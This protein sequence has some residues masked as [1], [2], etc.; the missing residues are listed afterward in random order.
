MDGKQKNPTGGINE[1]P[2]GAES[3]AELI[4]RLDFGKNL[5]EQL[6]EREALEKCAIDMVVKLKKE[7]PALDLDRL[8]PEELLVQA[9]QSEIKWESQEL[10][11]IKKIREAMETTA[12][13]LVK[14]DFTGALMK[15]LKGRFLPKVEEKLNAQNEKPLEMDQKLEAM[16]TEIERK[17]R[18]EMR[19][20]VEAQADPE[21]LKSEAYFSV[22][23]LLNSGAVEPKDAGGLQSMEN[24]SKLGSK[25]S[26]RAVET[27]NKLEKL[28]P[29]AFASLGLP[30][31]IR[32]AVGQF[33]RDR[34]LARLASEKPKEKET[35]WDKVS[36]KTKE[37]YRNH[38]TLSQ[39]ALVSAGAY[40][41]YRIIKYF[42]GKKA[43]E[44]KAEG[45]SKKEW[46]MGAGAIA[47]VGLGVFLGRNRMAQWF[48]EQFGSL[49]G[50]KET[51]E[52]ANA[53][54]EALKNGKP[55]E[56]LEL[57]LKTPDPKEELHQK[58]S[59]AFQGFGKNIPK[60]SLRL[61]SQM[62]YGAFMGQQENWTEYL[63]AKLN[64]T[65]KAFQGDQALSDIYA[66]RPDL[67]GGGKH[68]FEIFKTLEE[69]KGK[70]GKPL[71]DKAE[72]KT[73][74]VDEVL[75]EVLGKDLTTAQ[76][77]I[78]KQGE[79]KPER[80]NIG[81]LEYN[82]QLFSNAAKDMLKDFKWMAE[83]TGAASV[84][85]VIGFYDMK[86]SRPEDFKRKY[87]GKEA[88]FQM[89]DAID[90]PK[91]IIDQCNQQKIPIA[92]SAGAV[93]IYDGAKWVGLAAITP[94][95]AFFHEVMTGGDI[96]DA[97]AVYGVTASP[98]IV[99][100]AAKGFFA[101]GKGLN[102][103]WGAV[104]GGAKGAVWGPM[105]AVEVAY[106]AQYY[107]FRAREFARSK[108]N[109]AKTKIGE[110]TS[111]F[112]EAKTRA[113]GD[114][115]LALEERKHLLGEKINEKVAW[116]AK[117][118]W[119][120]E[121]D[122]IESEIGHLKNSLT[123]KG[124][125]PVE[126][127]EERIGL[128]MESI[129]GK[130]IN[131]AAAKKLAKKMAEELIDPEHFG[132]R[133][134][135][136]LL[137][138]RQGN[139]LT[140]LLANI[141]FNEAMVGALAEDAEL[142]KLLQD[143]KL[144]RNSA[145][146][147]SLSEGVKN[148]YLVEDGVFKADLVKAIAKET[149]E[150]PGFASRWMKALQEALGE[151]WDKVKD[152]VRQRQLFKSV[153]EKYGT[154]AEKA[155]KGREALARAKD[156]AIGGLKPAVAQG[157]LEE[158][159]KIAAPSEAEQREIN[160]LT[161]YL[162]R[163]EKALSS[164]KGSKLMETAWKKYNE[165]L[166][167]K[168]L[169][170]EGGSMSATRFLR[171]KSLFA[172]AAKLG[173]VAAVVMLAHSFENAE[174]KA[175]FIGQFAAGSL[176][177]AG[178][179]KLAQMGFKVPGPIYAKAIAGILGFAGGVVG[180]HYLESA[181]DYGAKT[182]GDRFFINRGQSKGWENVGSALEVLGGLGISNIAEGLDAADWRNIDLDDLVD[183]NGVEN[184]FAYQE[185]LKSSAVDLTAE[186]RHF[187]RNT[188][189]WNREIRQLIEKTEKEIGEKQEKLGTLSPGS[190]EAEELRKEIEK[191][192]AQLETVQENR[193]FTD[194]GK[195][196]EEW[197]A[198]QETLLG[199]EEDRL[200]SQKEMLLG[201]LPAHL[202]QPA[203]QL[204]VK[205]GER[206]VNNEGFILDTDNPE[207]EQLWL[208]LRDVAPIQIEIRNKEGEMET[209]DLGF[210]EWFLRFRDH[211]KLRF[212]YEQIRDYGKLPDLDLSGKEPEKAT[213]KKEPPSKEGGIE[214]IAQ[215]P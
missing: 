206:I 144:L 157:R 61:V 213:P 197:Q 199:G 60:D 172:G 154:L 143:K 128:Q 187:Y 78:A 90:F 24:W 37:F 161:R 171:Y 124:K 151:K 155:Q 69:A 182:V 39:I 123:S 205:I 168:T 80:D 190:E 84:Y 26:A 17:K 49:L 189:T 108:W 4:R 210:P 94:I 146:M 18:E 191:M 181:Y 169:A 85:D 43:E 177:I 195:L 73:K 148:G 120:E 127:I 132:T 21:A 141:E 28:N 45:A 83:K 135:K 71:I 139:R 165:L 149:V 116:S 7:N 164:I 102:G 13:S 117:K 76:E 1:T 91:A 8:S 178:G 54:A 184:P 173:G 176:G 112:E 10:E 196:S 212:N 147:E 140:R 25:L 33:N 51:V 131:E 89:G 122:A 38:T 75:E 81:V 162:E 27:S 188:S 167:D 142:W 88:G 134:S 203:H 194:D 214:R 96:T 160:R 126:I 2:R 31:I 109:L 192:S 137:F 68:L 22:L 9:E 32:E 115:I 129:Y 62:G 87:P 186:K 156:W 103:L 170:A 65:Q 107:G 180:A 153:S 159:K 47:V 202:E 41:A 179:V 119:K 166:G 42:W 77:S 6:A 100:G 150:D 5:K 36:G 158:L 101:N 138:E 110:K 70:D 14:L 152:N 106:D 30:R 97:I 118:D 95:G 105:K 59:V 193:M 58:A 175:D 74:T 35:L 98:F 53:M 209:K 130:K 52:K 92:V 93:L 29:V 67:S 86:W 201:N 72:A 20:Q 57:Y 34:A 79:A 113:Y 23:E 99:V 208:R 136:A 63:S 183:E 185:Y 114:R 121:V 3:E 82:H 200:E 204:I 16:R 215:N 145:F 50:I 44:R 66:A 48:K 163:E 40:G 111:F 198:N 133:L 15:K 207:E 19:E 46:L 104:K 174:N 64:Q 56:A 211:A 11:A 55:L 12:Y 125:I